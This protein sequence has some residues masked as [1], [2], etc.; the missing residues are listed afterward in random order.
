[1]PS[2]LIW[3]KLKNARIAHWLRAPHARTIAR[4]SARSRIFTV[5]LLANFCHFP[6]LPSLL[7]DLAMTFG[8]WYKL[9][10]KETEI[11]S[12]FRVRTALVRTGAYTNV[13]RIHNTYIGSTF[14]WK[15]I[16]SPNGYSEPLSPHAPPAS[17]CVRSDNIRLHST[18]DAASAGCC[19]L[20]WV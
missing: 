3:K 11:R 2:V 15:K 20:R 18:F 9:K 13:E 16:I 14:E 7:F 4:A 5:R 10:R 12:T 17:V 6:F 1:M 19:C 8:N